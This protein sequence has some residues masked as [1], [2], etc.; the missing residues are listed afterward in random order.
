VIASA[1]VER[2]EYGRWLRLLS[3]SESGAGQYRASARRERF[4]VVVEQLSKTITVHIAQCIEHVNLLAP[5][6]TLVTP[7]RGRVA[8]EGRLS[9]AV[10]QPL[11]G[12][13]GARL[14]AFAHGS[15]RETTTLPHKEKSAYHRRPARRVPGAHPR[16]NVRVTARA[17]ER[18]SSSCRPQPSRLLRPD[19]SWRAVGRWAVDP[20]HVRADVAWS[21]LVGRR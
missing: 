11:V 12:R 5:S 3:Y 20:N 2:E 9:A 13:V 8:Y 10:Q 19:S 17:A 1:E 6:L 7:G 15:G 18:K 4:A 16:S 21:A 14:T